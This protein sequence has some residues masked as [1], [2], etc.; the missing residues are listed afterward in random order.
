MDVRFLFVLHEMS[1]TELFN[2]SV[3]HQTVSD[4]ADVLSEQPSS[5]D[6]RQIQTRALQI[7]AKPDIRPEL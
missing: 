4:L 1:M 7:L 5:A 3:L 6:S 2:A